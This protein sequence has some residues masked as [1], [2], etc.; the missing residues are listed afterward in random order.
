MPPKRRSMAS[1]EP[2]T[3][4]LRAPV[5]P[6]PLSETP[7]EVRVNNANANEL[8]VA[9]DDALRRYIAHADTSFRTSHRHTDVKLV[10]GWASVIVAGLTAFYGY[11]VDFEKSK[12]AVWAGV[13]L[14]I[15]LSGAQTLYTYFIEGE[16][17]FIG[18]R[19]TYAKRVE[20][21]RIRVESKTLP[22]PSK[23]TVSVASITNAPSY[24]ISMSYLRTTNTGKTVIHM[25]KERAESSYAAFFDS[26]GKMDVT[27]F[28]SWVSSA[29]AKVMGIRSDNST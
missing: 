10:L 8:K 11:K 26:A 22:P 9:C 21:E 27:K 15:L 18:K 17:I 4:P 5:P 7:E 1:P 3:S 20:T 2:P 28:E 13:I 16:T 14:Y 12:P 24:Q 25:G 6:P 19:K 29:M 23:A